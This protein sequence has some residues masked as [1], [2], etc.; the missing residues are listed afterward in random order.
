MRKS[1]KHSMEQYLENVRLYAD[2]ANRTGLISVSVENAE[3]MVAT[4]EGS[5]DGLLFQDINSDE[6]LNRKLE[7]VSISKEAEAE[8]RKFCRDGLMVGI[9]DKFPRYFDDK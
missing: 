5:Y 2:Q 6:K 9:H 3:I 7:R 8:V 1:I 4:P